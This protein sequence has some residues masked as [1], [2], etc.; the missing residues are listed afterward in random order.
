M[1]LKQ[2][3]YFQA[4][5]ARGNISAAAEDLF[6]SRSVVS[7]AISE[8]EEE[9][10]VQIFLRS[11]SGVALTEGG[12]ILAQLFSSFTASC[13]SA[14]ARISALQTGRESWS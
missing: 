12:K 4:V 10:N 9:F 13:G 2:I 11:K 1:T 8:L 6:V 14:K 3:E 7:R 5:C